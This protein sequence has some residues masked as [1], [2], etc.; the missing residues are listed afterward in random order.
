MSSLQELY[1]EVERLFNEQIPPNLHELPFRLMESV[2][3]IGNELR[4]CPR[5]SR[6][7]YQR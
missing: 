6:S 3:R 2:E 5:A 7:R 4:G 1:D